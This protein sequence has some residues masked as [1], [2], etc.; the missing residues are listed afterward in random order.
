MMRGL[1]IAVCE[2]EPEEYEKLK[3][4]LD[5]SGREVEIDYFPEGSALLKS[6][7]AGKYDLVLLD[8]YMKLSLIHI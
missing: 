6:F 5:E 7:Y 8:I 2:D 3:R 4:L 1:K